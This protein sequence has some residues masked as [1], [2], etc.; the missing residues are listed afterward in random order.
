MRYLLLFLPLLLLAGCPGKKFKGDDAV[1][2][3]RA[4]T[5]ARAIDNYNTDFVEYPPSLRAVQSH[6]APGSSWPVNPY[7]NKPIEDTGSPEFDPQTSVG[8]VYYEKMHRNGVQVS[9][10]LH[11]FGDKGKLYIIG[12]TAMGLKE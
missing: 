2:M 9:Y 7:N 8:N 11:V 4:K 3:N 1:M 5:L 10:L 6:L 12:N